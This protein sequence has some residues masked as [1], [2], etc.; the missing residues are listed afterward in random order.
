MGRPSS[1]RPL[2]LECLESRRL[3]AHNVGHSPGGGG[4]PNN[5]PSADADIELVGGALTIVGSKRNDRII[6]DSDGTNVTVTF[7]KLTESFAVADVTSISI[8]GGKGN[9]RIEIAAELTGS[10]TV[11][12]GAGNDRI[13]GGGG[14]DTLSGDAGNDWIFGGDGD[15]LIDAGAGND[16]LLGDAG[17]DELLAGAGNDALNG[18]EGDDILRG[19]AGHDKARGGAGD[20]ELFGEANK[21]LLWGDDG[22]DF[23]DGG[24]DKDHLRGGNGDD[25]L[26]GA[27]GN[28][29]LDGGAGTNQLDGGEGKD[30]EVNGTPIDLDQVLSAALTSATVATAT[31]TATFGFTTAEGA[32]ESELVVTV[33]GY[34]ASSVLDVSV[35]GTVIGQITTDAS[36]NG[37]LVASTDPTDDTE[38]QIPDGLSITEGATVLV[39]TDLTGTLAVVV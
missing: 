17:N 11:T 29:H 34:T 31:G 26:S 3:L 30:K 18:G 27:A 21:D 25:I 32:A 19:G 16:H 20:D 15:D 5:G 1:C 4:K 14:S 10:A 38:L 36:G 7:N 39:A 23:L 37:T 33:Q 6:V 8:D 13:T 24:D 22:N 28:D 35:N 2:I 12:G 9:D